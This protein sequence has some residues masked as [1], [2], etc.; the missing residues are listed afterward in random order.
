[1]GDEIGGRPAE[2]DVPV[3]FPAV[4]DLGLRGLVQGLPTPTQM[5][6]RPSESAAHPHL[7]S[8][9]MDAVYENANFKG[10]QDG[11]F[12]RLTDWLQDDDSGLPWRADKKR[13]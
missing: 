2:V 1:M 8:L 4:A 12:R 3:A 10:G 7:R 6:N 5:G 11:P 13:R 9:I